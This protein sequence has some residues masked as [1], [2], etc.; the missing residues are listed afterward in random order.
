LVRL[1]NARNNLG[2]QALNASEHDVAE[3]LLRQA[4]SD[5]QDRPPKQEV[6]RMRALVHETRANLYKSTGRLSEAVESSRANVKAW[7]ALVA[8]FPHTPNLRNRLGQAWSGLGNHLR[9]VDSLDEAVAA[10]REA[11]RLYAALVTELP[12]ILDHQAGLARTSLNLGS[13]L[14]RSNR[15]DWQAEAS[16]HL[17]RAIDLAEH[18]HSDD[19]AQAEYARLLADCLGETGFSRSAA[20]QHELAKTLYERAVEAWGKAIARD[21]DSTYYQDGQANML[22]SVAEELLA[23]GDPQAA[24]AVTDRALL[25]L[26]RNLEGDP[27]NPARR[28]YA[29]QVIATRI[30]ACATVAD[31]GAAVAGLTELGALADDPDDALEA[32][33]LAARCAAGLQNEQRQAYL[34]GGIG[35]LGL[36]IDRGLRDARR[37]ERDPRFEALRQHPG[38]K[39]LQQRIHQ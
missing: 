11:V 9:Y 6:M 22:G 8:A 29:R 30:T 21:P 34:A 5:L 19:P 37:L 15:N 39:T 33:A 35:A 14:V 18:L 26:R 3:A 23:L 1:V 32:A 27:R 4:E 28:R 7:Q 17:Q 10:T 13:M 2:W 16:S 31:H 12:T 38:F 36:A 25:I 24:L 20:G